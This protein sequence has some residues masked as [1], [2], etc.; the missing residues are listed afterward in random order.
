MNNPYPPVSFYFRV[1]FNGVGNKT[2]DTQFQ[3]V[4]GLRVE[5]KT[6]S[7]KEG[8]ENRFEHQ[9][10]LGTEYAPLVLKRG[11]I[12]DSA[13]IKWCTETFE[14]LEVKPTTLDIMLLN[15]RSEPLMSWNVVHA[16]PVKWEVSDLEAQ[17]SGIAIETLELKYRYFTL[18]T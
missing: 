18:K 4:S 7:Y 5:V 9:L 10:P 6:E 16:W 12:K 14:T 17:E 11:L 2:I 8:G 15:P 1:S 13:L 3:S